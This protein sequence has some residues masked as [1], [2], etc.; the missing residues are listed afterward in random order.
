MNTIHEYL[1]QIVK[2]NNRKVAKLNIQSAPDIC[3]LS[4]IVWGLL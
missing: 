1:H 2:P 4:I 3:P